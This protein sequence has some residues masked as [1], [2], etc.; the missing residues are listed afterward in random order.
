[1]KRRAL[2]VTSACAAALLVLAL[3]VIGFAW[4]STLGLV[5]GIQARAEL[6]QKDMAL[7][8]ALEARLL[9][10]SGIDQAI[11]RIRGAI[12]SQGTLAP[13]PIVIKDNEYSPNAVTTI[14][15][16]R[17]GP[18]FLVSV[19]GERGQFSPDL[20]ERHVRASATASAKVRTGDDG[21][22]EVLDLV[23]NQES[24]RDR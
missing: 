10:R 20:A 18:L 8:R 13:G 16:G 7:T 5:R 15:I 12:R 3:G 2:V 4:I 11:A 22:F 24:P 9:A 1:V 19:R 21:R 17:E 23:E 14:E 6:E